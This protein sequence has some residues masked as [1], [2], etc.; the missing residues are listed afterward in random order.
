M[1]NHAGAVNHTLQSGRRQQRQFLKD[2]RSKEFVIYGEQS[3]IFMQIPAQRFQR[4]AHRPD[5]Q[6][7]GVTGKFQLNARQFKDPVNFGN[8]P[9]K[10]H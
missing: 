2:P 3:L 6:R 9:E 1:N 8:I 10:R 7:P 5:N 4:H